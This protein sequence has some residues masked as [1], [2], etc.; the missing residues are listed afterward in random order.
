MNSTTDGVADTLKTLVTSVTGIVSG[1]SNT[2][3][4]TTNTSSSSSFVTQNFNLS[5]VT[6]LVNDIN[7]NQAM[8]VVVANATDSGA[9]NL[10][11]SVYLTATT[12]LLNSNS[13][14][15]SVLNSMSQDASQSQTVHREGPRRLPQRHRRLAE[16]PHARPHR[17]RR[18]RRRRRPR[19]SLHAHARGRRAPC[20]R[21][22]G[23]GL[24]AA[25]PGTIPRPR[26]RPCTRG[27]RT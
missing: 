6:T 19:P 23:R 24:R 11:Q 20:A 14:T 22:Q 26:P 7:S 12:K 18:R 2:T 1:K 21:R 25:S 13:V 16:Q 8:K 10:A 3:T 27:P 4:N 9:Y 5:S 15:A 17:H